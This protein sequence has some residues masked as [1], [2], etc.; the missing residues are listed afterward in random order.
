MTDTTVDQRV[1]RGDLAAGKVDKVLSDRTALV[2]VDDVVGG[3]KFENALQIAEAAKIMATAGSMLPP[4]LQGNVGGCWGII[5]RAIELRMSPMTLASMTYEVENKGVR[6]VA[7]MSNFFRTIVEQRARIKEKRLRTRYEGTGDDMVCFVYATFDGDDQPCE[8]PPREAAEQYT[9][10]KL[11]PGRNDRGQIRGSPLWETKPAQQMFYAMSRDWARVYCSSLVAGMYT[12]EELREQEAR[13]QTA[14]DVTPHDKQPELRSRLR[15]R[16][17]R[18]GFHT[19][20]SRSIDNAIS[21]ARG[22]PTLAP[23]LQGEVTENRDG[24]EGERQPPAQSSDVAAPPAAEKSSADQS[25]SSARTRKAGAGEP[26]GDAGPPD[27]SERGASSADQSKSSAGNSGH[28]ADESAGD[29]PL[30][31]S[32]SAGQ[33]P[34]ASEKTQADAPKASPANHVWCVRCGMYFAVE[35]DICVC[36]SGDFSTQATEPAKAAA[37]QRGLDDRKAE[38]KR[39]ATPP[40]WRGP[41]ATALAL[42]W[43]EGWREEDDRQRSAT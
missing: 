8:W 32:S 1:T 35:P 10:K 25:L 29:D 5:L 42:A 17:G 4:W 41:E 20:I 43:I 16:E 34:L 15:G 23:M 2:A 7:Y 31:P 37:H 26:A 24:T 21:R 6:Q 27:T 18:E 3:L 13:A 39:S 19:D 30:P 9:L 22:G 33:S 12:E 38:R 40:E 11:R 28:A 14:K 36:G